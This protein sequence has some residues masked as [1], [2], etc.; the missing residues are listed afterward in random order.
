MNIVH[1]NFVLLS[2]YSRPFNC[3]RCF[4]SLV[5]LIFY[6]PLCVSWQR[7]AHATKSSGMLEKHTHTH[8][9][10]ISSILIFIFPPSVVFIFS[11]HL[12]CARWLFA[13]KVWSTCITQKLSTLLMNFHNHCGGWRWSEVPWRRQTWKRENFRHE[14]IL[15]FV[16]FE[17]PIS[18]AFHSVGFH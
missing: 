4:C 14:N 18:S 11:A 6:N 15:L 2:L 12:G 8:I 1:N 10:D 9:Q 3:A 13:H 16:S 17:I 5:L 7:W